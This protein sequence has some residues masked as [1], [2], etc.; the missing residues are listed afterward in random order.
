MEDFE[1]HRAG[2]KFSPRKRGAQKPDLF[3]ATGI[4]EASGQC[5]EMRDGPGQEHGY[6]PHFFYDPVHTSGTTHVSFDLRMEANHQFVHEWRDGSSPYRTSVYLSINNGTLTAGG[7]KLDSLP[8]L[9]WIHFE[10]EAPVG[11]DADGSWNLRYTPKGG[12]TVTVEKLPPQKTGGT[13]VRW[14]GFIN[15][16]NAAT[17]AWLDNITIDSK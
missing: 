6:D 9:T 11:K 13:E 12:K 16:G 1:S 7:R 2:E 5:L 3:I 17:K 14:L 15:P 8:P 4:P 10:V